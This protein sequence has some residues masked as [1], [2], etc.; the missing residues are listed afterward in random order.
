[1]NPL[2]SIGIIVAI[3]VVV[4]AVSHWLHRKKVTELSGWAHQHGWSYTE[5]DNNVL[6]S[7]SGQP[8]NTRGARN[9]EARHV[10][11]GSYRGHQALVFEYKYTTRSSNKNASS[12]TSRYQVVA[13]QL[14]AHRPTLEVN[15][16]HFGHKLLELVG[17]H[18]LQLPDEQFNSTFRV[19]TN[20]DRFAHDVL[21]PQMMRWLLTDSRAT[22]FPLRFEGHY[23]LTWNRGN[24]KIDQVPA[25]LDYLVDVLAQLPDAVLGTEPRR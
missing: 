10:V 7:F 1:M 2:V 23:L 13:L 25:H 18:D 12:R 6:R 17:V 14:P 5:R 3:V 16:E 24:L 9:R 22:Q 4:L 11:T 20:H 21:H 15:R 8:F 19:H